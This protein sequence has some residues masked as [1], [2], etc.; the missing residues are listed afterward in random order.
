MCAVSNTQNLYRKRLVLV[1]GFDSAVRVMDNDIQND[2]A[3][4]TS[5]NS[6]AS[7]LKEAIKDRILL[8]AICTYF[9]GRQRALR[10]QQTSYGTFVFRKFQM[11]TRLEKSVVPKIKIHKHRSTRGLE[12]SEGQNLKSLWNTKYSIPEI[13]LTEALTIVSSILCPPVEANSRMMKDSSR[14]FNVWI[15]L[16][17]YAWPWRPITDLDH[18]ATFSNLRSWFYTSHVVREEVKW[19]A[20]LQRSSTSV[21]MSLSLWIVHYRPQGPEPPT[22]TM[23]I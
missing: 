23:N 21:E 5:M 11:I 9:S 20:G 7:F 8:S 14:S 18:W 19:L 12:V 16:P 15:C 4:A 3:G 13:H 10:E 6:R 2:P 22:L 17:G 1:V